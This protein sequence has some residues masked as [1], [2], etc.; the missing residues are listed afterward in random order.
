MQENHMGHVIRALRQ[1]KG[2]TQK[3]LAEG[4]CSVKQLSRIERGESITNLMFVHQFSEKM[5]E[6]LSDFFLIAH[7]LDPINMLKTLKELEA[8]YL[9]QSFIEILDLV[10]KIEVHNSQ[11]LTY[12][13]IKQLIWWYKGVGLANIRPNEID[14]TYFLDLLKLSTDK[15]IETLCDSYMNNNEFRIVHS[16]IAMLCRKGKFEIA[17]MLLVKIINSIE[18]HYFRYDQIIYNE[19]LYNLT[20]IYICEDHFEKAIGVAFKGVKNSV[21]NNCIAGVPDFIF[22]AGLAYQKM[23]KSEKAIQQYNRFL[24]LIKVTGYNRYTLECRNEL[25]DEFGSDLTE[26]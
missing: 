12:N 2:M 11:D 5:G 13:N 9:K 21:K 8:L 23:G 7:C 6:N 15:P 4:I 20:K 19:M 25:I 26:F 22:M 14:E 24:N 16:Y 3:E 17:R 10:S 18:R 1:L